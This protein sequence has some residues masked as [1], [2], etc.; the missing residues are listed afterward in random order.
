MNILYIVCIVCI[1]VMI[2]LSYT[3]IRSQ[4]KNTHEHL[5]ISTN[6]N[7]TINQEAPQINTTTTGTTTGT[8]A[9]E[10][11]SEIKPP[12]KRPILKTKKDPINAI[13]DR[14]INN[15]IETKDFKDGVYGYRGNMHQSQL[16]KDVS[17]LSL[18][19]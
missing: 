9:R 15:I 19:T 6:P 18:L 7:L 5:V 10:S 12:T 14:H 4:K 16:K 13:H 3:Y 8:L 11:T 1:M 17:I 2:L